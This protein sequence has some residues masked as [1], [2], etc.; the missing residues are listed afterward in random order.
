MMS[1]A[2]ATIQ[3]MQ[4]QG[5][6]QGRRATLMLRESDV[7]TA[8]SRGLHE[9]DEWRV[10]SGKYAGT[11]VIDI[12]TAAVIGGWHRADIRWERMNTATSAQE[13]R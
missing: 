4:G 9:G 3:Q 12:P 13:S 5:L 6:V 8:L 10:A 1:A 11:W 7:T 2:S